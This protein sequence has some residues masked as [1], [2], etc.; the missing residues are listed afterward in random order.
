MSYLPLLDFSTEK[1]GNRYDFSL[2]F[3]QEHQVKAI[4]GSLLKEKTNLEIL[5]ENPNTQNIEYLKQH[6]STLSNLVNIIATYK[7]EKINKDKIK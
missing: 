5:L 3:L 4:L 2:M 7:P 1:A 6:L